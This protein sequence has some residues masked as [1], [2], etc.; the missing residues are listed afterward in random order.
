[1]LK[2]AGLMRVKIGSSM[3]IMSFQISQGKY[4]L[5]KTLI[6]FGLPQVEI[7]EG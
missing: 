5:F 4:R 2:Y 7:W 1:M 6:Y 3:V